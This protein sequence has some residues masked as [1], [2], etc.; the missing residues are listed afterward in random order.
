MFWKLYRYDLY[1]H[2]GENSYAEEML[3]RALYALECA[4]HPAFSPAAAACRLD[5]EDEANR[6]LFTALFRHLQVR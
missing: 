3:A 2:M 5:Y 6:P 4:W 1:R